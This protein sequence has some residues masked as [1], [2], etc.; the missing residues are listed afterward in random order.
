[1]KCSYCS[2]ELPTGALFCG[3][4]GRAVKSTVAPPPRP[5]V[6]RPLT[7]P[8]PPPSPWLGAAVDETRCDQCGSAMLRE[9]IFCPECGFVSQAVSKAFALGGDPR[10][11]AVVT[12]ISAGV[13]TLTEAN[14]EAEPQ[15]EPE[16]E[17]E[18]AAEPEWEPEPEAELEPEPEP[19]PQP[20]PEPEAAAEPAAEP[21][22]G[23]EP[24]LE[25][26]PVPALAEPSTAFEDVEA[27]RIVAPGVTGER[28]V[29]QFSTGESYTVFGSGLVGRNPR[30]E[31]GEYFDQL[32]AVV[33]PT[34][35]VSKTHL[36]YGQESGAFWVRDR[37]SG[38]GTV[39][40]EPE[41][42]PRRLQADRRYRVIRGSRIDIGEQFFIVS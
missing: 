18:A 1:M 9:D 24:A 6:A 40:R 19:E 11:T 12:P 29:L 38:N 27:T 3:E 32:L 20:E 14:P 28:F 34:R 10:D 16:P 2:T 26:E 33:D 8:A 36:E 41:A 5:I 35:S 23:P 15:P 21:E 31:P 17:P 22:A 42:L 4:C 39:L 37:F 30:P 25:P 7:T 13:P